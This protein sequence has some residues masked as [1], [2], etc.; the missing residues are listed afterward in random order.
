VRTYPASLNFY[1]RRP[2]LVSSATGRELTSNYILY[3]LDRARGA[4]GSTLRAADWWH[5]AL[6]ACGTTR[7]FVVRS[8]WSEA[9]Q[10]LGA[11]LPLVLDNGRFATYGPCRGGGA[12]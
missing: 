7:F 12:S 4:P 8:R 11:R 10:E 9:R 3:I 5:Q 1:L 6:A 2:I